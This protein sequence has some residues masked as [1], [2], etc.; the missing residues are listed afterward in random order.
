MPLEQGQRVGNYEVLNLLG[1]GG[2]GRVYRVRNIISNRVE[3]MKILLAAE[4]CLGE[5]LNSAHQALNRSDPD[6]ANQYLD[7]A[8]RELTTLESF[9]G[10]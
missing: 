7:R 1:A 4:N 5:D 6:S 8:E 9:L 2:M 3:A 10:R